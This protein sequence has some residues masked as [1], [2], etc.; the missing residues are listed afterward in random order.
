MRGH[1]CNRHQADRTSRDSPV[2]VPS[3]TILN[4]ISHPVPAHTI[5]L[6]D[7]LGRGAVL[8]VNEDGEADGESGEEGWWDGGVGCG[9]EGRRVAGACC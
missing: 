3:R 8:F 5:I 2:F 6:I 7:L 9:G 4:R 1:R